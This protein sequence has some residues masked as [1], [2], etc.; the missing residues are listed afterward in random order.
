MAGDKLEFEGVVTAARGNGMF[1][2]E[3]SGTDSVVE[4]SC[5]LSGKIRKNNIKILE[6]DKV[7][8]EVTPFDLRKGRI[9]YRMRA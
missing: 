1:S 5:T 2:V 8:I 6:G 7:K 4:V 9:V 3:L